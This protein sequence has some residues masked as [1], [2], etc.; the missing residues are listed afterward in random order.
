MFQNDCSLDEYRFQVRAEDSGTPPL[1]STVD[2]IAE[3]IDNNDRSLLFTK[4][5]YDV[6]VKENTEPGACLLKVR[7]HFFH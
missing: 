7:Y 2:V 6:T 5:L 4:P 3:I 1:S